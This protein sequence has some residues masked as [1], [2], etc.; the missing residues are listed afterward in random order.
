MLEKGLIAGQGVGPRTGARYR[1]SAPP[2]TDPISAANRVLG[3]TVSGTNWRR[4][5][6]AVVGAVLAAVLLWLAAVSINLDLEV[7]MRSGQPPMVIG[8][9]LVIVIS[10][11]FSLLGWGSLVLFERLT[12]RAGSIWTTV[13]A[14]VLLLSLLPI[15]SAEASV[16]TKAVLTAMH[17]AVA[18]VLMAVLPRRAPS[19]AS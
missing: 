5:L 14:A 19:P 7:D 2:G 16:G 13:A 8:L 9:P 1:V 15:V 11:V 10:L 18:A 17:V 3:R 6:L 12:N 4:G